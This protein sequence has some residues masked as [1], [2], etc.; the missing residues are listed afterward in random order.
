MSSDISDYFTF[1]SVSEGFLGQS[2]KGIITG[3]VF[4]VLLLCVCFMYSLLRSALE[5]SGMNKLKK[6]CDEQ[7]NENKAAQAV[8]ANA[9]H[10]RRAAVTGMTLSCSAVTLLTV[11]TYTDLLFQALY[12]VISVNIAAY[13]AAVCILFL[14]A[15]I[16]TASVGLILPEKLCGDKPEEL[17]VKQ[18]VPFVILAKMMFPA[19]ALCAG[20]AR[21]TARLLGKKAAEASKAATEERILKMVDEGEENGS[22]E[23]NTRSMIENIFDFDDT[24]VGTIMTHRKD[25]AAV[26]DNATLNELLDLAAKSGNSR[27]P[28][29]H[30]NIDSIIGIIYVKDLLAYVGKK[31]HDTLIPPKLIRKAVF[32]PES[33]RC[34]EMFEYMTAHKTQLAVVVDEFGGT[35]GIITMEDL[36]ESIVGNIQ[37]EYDNEDE[38]IKQVSDHSFYV[39]GAASLDEI[40]ELT[41][42]DFTNDDNDSAAGFML[43][44]LGD[45]P[46]PGEHPSFTIDGIQFSVAESDTKRIIRILIVMPEKQKAES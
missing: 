32:V 23:E 43:D 5:L 2:S 15:F 13:L 12:N 1:L 3:T 38:E 40:S 14:T 17:L 10:Y 16:I 46:R 34:S 25:I 35:G 6:F 33:K 8:I 37:D 7:E 11:F 22:I 36:I 42:I 41:G 19:A 28:V 9:E 4:I 18:A 26:P 20:I 24:T 39:D 29:Y 30:E 21:L 27:I 45:I 31:L 44:R